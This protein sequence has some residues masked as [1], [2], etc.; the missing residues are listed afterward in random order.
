MSEPVEKIRLCEECNTAFHKGIDKL[1]RGK[2]GFDANEIAK[3]QDG[4]EQRPNLTPTN[5]K[6][7][8]INTTNCD[9]CGNWQTHM[10]FYDFYT[11]P[12]EK[13]R[14][15]T[16]GGLKVKRLGKYVAVLDEDYK[17]DIFNT[18]NIETCKTVAMHDEAKD[19]DFVLHQLHMGDAKEEDFSDALEDEEDGGGELDGPG[20]YIVPGKDPWKA[21]GPYDAEDVLSDRD[22]LSERIEDEASARFQANR[23][24][25]LT[26]PTVIIEAHDRL[27]A[28][29]GRGHVW[30]I[31]GLRKGLPV[32]PRQAALPFGEGLPRRLRPAPSS[33]EALRAQ[34][35]Q[36]LSSLQSEEPG[37]REWYQ[38]QARRKPPAAKTPRP[39][40]KPAAR[41][42]TITSKAKVPAHIQ[43]L[44]DIAAR[45]R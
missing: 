18:I 25:G 2:D 1:P 41:A 24:K 35:R 29:Q 28:L 8:T 10:R 20:F 3:I 26:Q 33:T 38:D 6:D 31:D 32:D 16:I 19:I 42:K 17:K 5:D 11:A 45:Y 30:W 15:E 37:T 40:A 43:K 34:G 9:N 21:V 4:F 13:A 23:K 36:F 39:V 14:N 27:S 22:T 7:G 12:I 44:K